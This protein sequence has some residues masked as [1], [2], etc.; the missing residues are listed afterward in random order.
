MATAGKLDMM[1]RRF[2]TSGALSKLVSPQLRLFGVEGRYA[3]ALYSAASK[4]KKLEA[5]EKDLKSFQDLLRK[6]KKFAD[7]VANPTVKRT[8]K[9]DVVA[10]VTKKLNY[11]PLSN[12][13]F[14]A[15][16]DNGRL[17]VIDDVLDAFNM[18][19][20]S[21]RGEVT[22]VITT[23]K[24]LDERT[25]SDL[26]PALESFLEQGETKLSIKTKVEPEII[27]GMR[28]EIG[29]KYIDMSMS[30]K[31]KTLSRLIAESV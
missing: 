13:F 27:G 18:L 22:C 20:S 28:V 9:R 31:I 2:S 5:V 23:A 25:L 24:P 10:G 21:H 11:S 26:K 16:A 30:T 15:L 12:N 3:H 6:D 7:Y 19:M 17:K 4:D 1:A 8:E 14:T 29:E